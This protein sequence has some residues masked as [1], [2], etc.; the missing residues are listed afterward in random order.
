MCAYRSVD[1][2][3]EERASHERLPPLLQTAPPPHFPALP[4]TS[5]LHTL[6]TSSLS[7]AYTTAGDSLASA[8][9][10][11]CSSSS[12]WL[13]TDANSLERTTATWLRASSIASCMDRLSCASATF[14]RWIS[15]IVLAA[16]ISSTAGARG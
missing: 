8:A 5:P 7:L 2:P 3:H 12:K 15:S 16:Y 14:C 6:S 11:L 4:H 1:P 10:C 13:L 9:S